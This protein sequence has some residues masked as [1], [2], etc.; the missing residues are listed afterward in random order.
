[1]PTVFRY[2]LYVAGRAPH[3]A[4]A[5]ENLAALCSQYPPASHEIEIVDVLRHPE[6]AL[7]DGIYMTPVLVK[8]A[9]KPAVTILGSLE[10]L[11]SVRQALGLGLPQASG[12]A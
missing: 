2:R 11:D 8:L 5:I 3:S 4:K 7:A 1:M 12:D 9:P 10:E 6:R